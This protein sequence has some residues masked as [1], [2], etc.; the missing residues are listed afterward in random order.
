MNSYLN[1]RFLPALS[2][3]LK[4][5]EIA[6]SCSSW[7]S[8]ERISSSNSTIGVSMGTKPYNLKYFWIVSTIACLFRDS[9]G[10]KSWNPFTVSMLNFIF[11]LSLTR[12]CSGTRYGKQRGR[13]ERI[14]LSL[15][16]PQADVLPLYYNRHYLIE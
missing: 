10:R 15:S 7:S 3:S 8:E 11:Y 14:E 9:G 13:E 16:A 2:F 6:S 1:P 12:S 5:S 4:R